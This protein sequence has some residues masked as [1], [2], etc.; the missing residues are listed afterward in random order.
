MKNRAKRNEYKDRAAFEGDVGLM[1]TNAITFN[2]PAHFITNLAQKLQS[3]A[4][5]AI[6]GKKGDIETMECVIKM[7]GAGHI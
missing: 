2:G 4:L 5:L 3:K 7:D 6:E 1:V